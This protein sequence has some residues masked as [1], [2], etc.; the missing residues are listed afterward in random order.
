MHSA[1]GGAHCQVRTGSAEVGR[2]INL[3]ASMNDALNN[4]STWARKV[5]RDC[6]GSHHA[7]ARTSRDCPT[8]WACTGILSTIPDSLR[9]LGIATVQSDG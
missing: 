5:G 6:L 3:V 1:H 8:T 9:K 7:P 4:L 2:A